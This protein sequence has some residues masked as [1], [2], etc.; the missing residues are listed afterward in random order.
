MSTMEATAS[1]NPFMV[2]MVPPLSQDPH[3][4][5]AAPIAGPKTQDQGFCG[6]R[7]PHTE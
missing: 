5:G 2:V 7:N 1:A 3:F 4:P 6:E